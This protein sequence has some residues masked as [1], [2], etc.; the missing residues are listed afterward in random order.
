[1]SVG[2]LSVAE[3][4]AVLEAH[5]LRNAACTCL[6]WNADPDGPLNPAHVRRQH[7]LHQAH[8]VLAIPR[9]R[10]YAKP[11]GTCPVCAKGGAVRQDGTLQTH[12]VDGSI[13]RGSNQPP[14]PEGV[15][16]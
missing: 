10:A 6:G 14:Q 15:P 4:A 5:V 1:M 13:C 9:G 8:M 3:V 11:R 16:T 12:R 7:V 2:P